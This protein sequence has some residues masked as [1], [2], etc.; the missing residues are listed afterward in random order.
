LDDSAWLDGDDVWRVNP[1]S[2]EDPRLRNGDINIAHVLQTYLES[3]FRYIILSSV[4]ITIPEI[5]KRILNMVEMKNYILSTFILRCD[6][7]SLRQRCS[8]RNQSDII[9]HHWQELDLNDDEIPIDTTNKDPKE[10][11]REIIK[12]VTKCG[13]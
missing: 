4:V 3:N 10:I 13:N 9:S 2:L 7:E 8:D 11:A 1:F 12:I 6:K 5:R